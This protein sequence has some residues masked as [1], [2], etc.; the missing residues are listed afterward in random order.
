MSNIHLPMSMCQWVVWPKLTSF[1]LQKVDPIF[2][3]YGVLSSG[4]WVHWSAD[5]AAAKHTPCW[6][7][8]LSASIASL[9]ECPRSASS[10]GLIN[11]QCQ[12]TFISFINSLQVQNFK[13][14]NLFCFPST[15]NCLITL[16]WLF[17]K[18]VCGYVNCVFY[19]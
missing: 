18:Q 11:F 5:L 14:F 2:R 12:I 17:N 19:L 8:V 6:P 4:V 9:W 1:I 15:I 16:T 13:M 3:R 10:H 7:W